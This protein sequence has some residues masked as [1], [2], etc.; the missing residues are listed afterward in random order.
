MDPELFLTLSKL[1]AIGEAGPDKGKSVA[2]ILLDISKS[3]KD[4]VDVMKPSVASP[5]AKPEQE[6]PK[7]AVEAVEAVEAVVEPKPAV[8]ADAE[9]RSSM[10][11]QPQQQA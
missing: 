9:P 8:E 2:T 11:T 1:F 4:L 6:A 5:P 7:P 3:L 10:Y